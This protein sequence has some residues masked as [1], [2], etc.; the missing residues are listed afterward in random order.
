MA[1]FLKGVTER[2]K[3]IEAA[4]AALIAR[5]A[6]RKAQQAIEYK[7]DIVRST[8]IGD[9]VE[10]NQVELI[11]ND[12][13]ADGWAL[14]SAVETEVRGRVGPGGV[15]GLMLIFERPTAVAV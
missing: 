2:A 12:R 14:K 3:E 1:D 9:R 11:L 6:E 7:V 10:H 13:A 15:M 5:V 8:I 4:E